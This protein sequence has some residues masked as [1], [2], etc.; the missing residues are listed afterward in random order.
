MGPKLGS[1]LCREGAGSD[2]CV[3]KVTLESELVTGHGGCPGQR[4][5]S[6]GGGR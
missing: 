6:L 2:V 3:Y 4:R 5:H 1:I